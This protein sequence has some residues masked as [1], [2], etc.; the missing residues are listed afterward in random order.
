MD[1]QYFEHPKTKE[2][3]CLLILLEDGYYQA[4]H[5]DKDSRVYTLRFYNL[6]KSFYKKWNRIDAYNFYKIPKNAQSPLEKIGKI[7]KT[8]SDLTKQ[9]IEIRDKCP[10]ID[11]TILST[12]SVGE[13]FNYLCNDCGKRWREYK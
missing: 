7:N 11:K 10:H 12:G 3:I 4:I 6:D 1:W 13:C 9:I 5:R 8:I 2:Q